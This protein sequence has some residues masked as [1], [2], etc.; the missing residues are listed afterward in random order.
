MKGDH[1]MVYKEANIQDK[2]ELHDKKE[3]DMVKE[4]AFAVT[5]TRQ[6]KTH[7]NEDP[8]DASK[9]S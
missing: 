9:D 4:N 6:Q 3:V 2:E 1:Y 7:A 5:K 8:P